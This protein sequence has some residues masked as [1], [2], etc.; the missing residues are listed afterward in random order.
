MSTANPSSINPRRTFAIISHPDAGKTTLMNALTGGNFKTANYP[1][2]TV[3]LLRGSSK[4]EFG[5]PRS[6]VDLPGVHSSVSPSPEEELAVHR[7]PVADGHVSA[8]DV[9]R[10]HAGEVDRILGATEL[11]RVAKLGFFEVIDRRTHLDRHGQRADAS[12]RDAGGPAAH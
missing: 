5:A 7:A 11:R 8:D 10:H 2:V 3:S 4:P 6:I 12:R 1:G 9:R